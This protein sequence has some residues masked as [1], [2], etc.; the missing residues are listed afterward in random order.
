MSV[1]FYMNSSTDFNCKPNVERRKIPLHK[2]MNLTHNRH[3]QL[4]ITIEEAIEKNID[5]YEKA[6]WISKAERRKA[7]ETDNHWM[8]TVFPTDRKTFYVYAASDIGVLLEYVSDL[9]IWPST[10]EVDG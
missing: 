1:G 4:G 3:F 10:E 7:I 8:I 9:K 6:D 2:S 5:G